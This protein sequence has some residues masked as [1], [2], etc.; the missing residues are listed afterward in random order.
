MGRRD[1][2]HM[3]QAPDPTKPQP[4]LLDSTLA[5]DW[6]ELKLQLEDL[7]AKLEYAKLMLKLNLKA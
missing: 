7:H 5:L 3:D 6:H 2:G 4:E 1:S